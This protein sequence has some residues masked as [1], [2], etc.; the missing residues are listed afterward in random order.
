MR[1]TSASLL[2]LGAYAVQGIIWITATKEKGKNAVDSLAVFYTSNIYKYIPGK[3]WQFAYITSE[4]S[5]KRKGVR[6]AKSLLFLNILSVLLSFSLLLVYFFLH[7]SNYLY[8]LG[9]IF[10][11][12]LV[13]IS[14]HFVDFDSILK[15]LPFSFLKKENEPARSAYS[16]VY[17]ELAAYMALFSLAMTLVSFK[18]IGGPAFLASSLLFIGWALGLLAFFLPQGIGVREASIVWL[19]NGLVSK[20]EMMQLILYFRFFPLVFELLLFAVSYLYLMRAQRT[21]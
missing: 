3:V 9:F 19:L 1:L 14:L 18:N 5:K 7:K 6:Y 21:L 20:E 2:V 17:I 8:L 13:A 4:G 11:T 15:K 10:A 16:L 12:L